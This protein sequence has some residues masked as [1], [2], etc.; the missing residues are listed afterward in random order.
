MFRLFKNEKLIF[1]SACLIIFIVIMGL[2]LGERKMLSWSGKF[3]KDIVSITQSLIYSPVAI[4]EDFFDNVEMMS[5]VYEENKALKKKLPDY[6]IDTIRLNVLEEQVGRLEEAKL[7]VERQKQVNRYIWHFAEVVS[8]SPNN[9]IININLGEK[10]GIRENMAVATVEGL[11]GTVHN[12]ASYSSSVQLLSAIDHSTKAIAATTKENE[13]SFGIIERYICDDIIERYNCDDFFEMNKIESSDSIKRGDT[14]L[15]SGYGGVFPKD[16][17]I[18][19]VVSKAVSVSGITQTA[20]IR[21]A[22]NLKGF[23]RQ[24]FVI[25]V[26]EP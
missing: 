17:I 25:E 16:I 10:D 19:T 9:T 1:L 8:V 6:A 22:V 12:V 23:I 3:A 2:T 15:T 4:A 7:F 24:V 5:N 21:P 20:I 11:I 14:V 18:G 13:E 26:P